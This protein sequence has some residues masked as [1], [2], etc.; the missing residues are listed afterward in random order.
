MLFVLA[1]MAASF[2]ASD[3]KFREKAAA[4]VW[5]LQLDFMDPK[6]EIPE[7]FSEG[8][9][10]VIIGAY[11]GVTGEKNSVSAT[12]SFNTKTT[13]TSIDRIM[14]KLLDQSAV[15]YY[16]DFSYSGTLHAKR[17]NGIVQRKIE[18]AFGARIHKPDGSTQEVDLSD[19]LAET[20]GKK[21][22]KVDSYKIAIPG[23]EV[24]DVLEYFYYTKEL[25]EGL[26][27]ERKIFTF[28]K[29]Y[30]VK[31]LKIHGEFD[32]ELT[33]ECRSVNGAHPLAASKDEAGKKN[34]VDLQVYDISAMPDEEW[35]LPLRQIPFI[36]MKVLNNTSEYG[37][38]AIKRR[39]GVHF[40]P[41][42]IY[43][44]DIRTILALIDAS[45]SKVLRRAQGIA[46]NYAKQHPQ[47]SRKEIADAAWLAI[48]YSSLIEKE[49]LNDMGLAI[50]MQEILKS[51]G[52][53]GDSLGI[54][55]TCSRESY[56]VDDI[57][58]WDDP[59]F[60]AIANG[61]IYYMDLAGDFT[62]GEFPGSYAGEKVSAFMGDRDKMTKNTLMRE[63]KVSD[64][65]AAHNSLKQNLSLKI[66]LDGAESLLS[67][68]AEATGAVKGM[69][70]LPQDPNKYLESVEEFL[71]IPEKNRHKKI[72][73]DDVAFAKELEDFMFDEAKDQLGASPSEI[74]SSEISSWGNLPSSPAS[75]WQMECKISDIADDLG[76]NIEL[77]VGML[78]GNQK[79]LTAKQKTRMLDVMIPSP[80]QTVTTLTIEIPQGYKADAESLD[81]IACNATSTAGQVILQPQLLDESTLQ[82]QYLVRF[83]KSYVPV[84]Q[85]PNFSML[86]DAASDVSASSIILSKE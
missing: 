27:P 72:D 76:D 79:K 37:I 38:D 3:K 49:S 65:R 12:R 71:E 45:D 68:K 52:F 31:C 56:S 44:G 33:I 10:A 62:P 81:A 58:A 75:S 85:W 9:S 36:E 32:P 86:I 1:G 2:G 59:D 69:I 30:P 7:E 14:V 17:A 43:Y 82:L 67:R 16:T 60:V 25:A 34:T 48:S 84:E 4:E 66:G 26:A 6:A 46:K 83:N 20:S 73:F 28:T 35:S 64:T 13:C 41:A 50:C 53:E 74:L 77:K 54:G 24:G 8:Q 15:D 80:W 29:R 40:L 78:L 19:A 55:F 5:G 57:L 18:N 42:G 23:L 63:M 70:S 39:A 47:A 61:N 11:Y 51:Q 22:D 21:G